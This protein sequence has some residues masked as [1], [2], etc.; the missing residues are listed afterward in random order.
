LIALKVVAL[1]ATVKEEV[2]VVVV[3]H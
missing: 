2:V 3:V 1:V